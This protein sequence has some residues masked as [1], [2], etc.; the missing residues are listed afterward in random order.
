M[1]R[2][3]A[4]RV[5]SAS[6][7]R[8]GSARR[9]ET[10]QI[11][12][13]VLE[14]WIPQVRQAL[15]CSV[16]RS[17]SAILSDSSRRDANAPAAVRMIPPCGRHSTALNV[18]ARSDR[19]PTGRIRAGLWEIQGGRCFYCQ[20]RVG[21]PL[22]VEVD[23]SV[24]WSRYPDDGLDNFVVADRECNGLKSNSLA[25]SRHLAGWTRRFG[26]GS[27]E[28]SQL[29]LLADQAGWDRHPDQSISVARAIY[30]RL[31]DDSRLWL[32]GRD[33]VAQDQIIIAEALA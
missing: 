1:E 15:K 7:V 31:P 3:I 11:R 18:S 16:A 30:L 8:I 24:P 17:K 25:A 2:R 22:N 10:A 29:A 14:P 4:N 26:T 33:Y 23:H 21:D 19:T 5:K 27:S 6:V 13:S 28:H 12:Q 9:S 20:T 32:G